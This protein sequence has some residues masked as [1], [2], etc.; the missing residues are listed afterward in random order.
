M[1]HLGAPPPADFDVDI[2][3]AQVAFFHEHGYLA[4]GRITTDDELSWLRAAYDSLVVG[5]PNKGMPH[6]IY[7]TTRPYGEPGELLL[8]QVLRPENTVP[9]ITQTALWRNARRVALRLLDLPDRDVEH[10]GH[11]VHKPA[12]IGKVTPW[13]QDEGYWDPDLAYHAVGAWTPLDDATIDNGCMW[14]VP[15]SHK[16]PIHRHRHSQNNPAIATLELVDKVDVSGAVAVPLRAGEVSFHHPRT[17][18]YAGPNI[19]NGDRRA[20]ANEFQSAPL[21][22]AIPADRPWVRAAH[23]AMRDV[24]IK[25]DRVKT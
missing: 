9:Q 3:A 11:L 12:R 22:L 18:H 23:Q 1:N 15:G 21:R 13:H 7:D 16:Q 25:R 8:G 20:W 5:R 4:L 14:F 24:Y 2:T 17:L 6:S 19:T 10:W